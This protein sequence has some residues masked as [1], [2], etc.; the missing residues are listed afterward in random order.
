MSVDILA[1]YRLYT[2]CQ[3]GDTKP[4]SSVLRWVG[5]NFLLIDVLTRYL[6]KR[7]VMMRCIYLEKPQLVA[8][9]N[10]FTNNGFYGIKHNFS[11]IGVYD[12][13]EC[14]LYSL[15]LFDGIIMLKVFKP[16]SPCNSVV[17]MYKDLHA[18]MGHL[19]ALDAIDFNTAQDWCTRQDL[20]DVGIKAF[21]TDLLSDIALPTIS[22]NLAQKLVRVT[23]VND[24][25]YIC[26]IRGA[27][28]SIHVIR[29]G[30]I[31]NCIYTATCFLLRAAT[32]CDSDAV[33]IP[34]LYAGKQLTG[35]SATKFASLPISLQDM[36]LCTLP[37]NVAQQL[38][39]ALKARKLL[40]NS[41]RYWL[42]NS[43]SY[44]G[45]SKSCQL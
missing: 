38:P 31:Y 3:S 40:G 1:Q 13:W 22:V 16:L 41:C 11:L 9:K 2:R 8:T 24:S 15:E 25:V 23:S 34:K 33:I 19:E 5:G 30:C 18:A 28:G 4:Y 17:R 32:C 20:L 42:N 35:E 36:I 10:R 27:R 6:P 7:F 44:I 39:P 26:M 12:S 43:A 21:G 14:V 37:S 45:S 29:N